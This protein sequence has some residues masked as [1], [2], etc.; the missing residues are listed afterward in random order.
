MT[1]QVGNR[2]KVVAVAVG[3]YPV[4]LSLGIS[5][6]LR[7]CYFVPAV[8]RNVICISFLTQEDYVISFYKDHCNIYF[9]INKIES[10]FLINNLFQLYMD[11]SINYIEEDMNA[12]GIK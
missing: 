9:K 4:R 12:I 8:S 3:T 5:L 11:V 7:D 10:D 2:V 1:L 6:V